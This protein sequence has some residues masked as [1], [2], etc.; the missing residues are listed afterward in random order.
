MSSV[1]QLKIHKTMLLDI[2]IPQC[3]VAY[4]LVPHINKQSKY[5]CMLYLTYSS[6]KAY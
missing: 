5:S 2:N 3:F 1:I 6:P 4:L